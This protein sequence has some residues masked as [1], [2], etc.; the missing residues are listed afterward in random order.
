MLLPRTCTSLSPTCTMRWA[1]TVATLGF[2]RCEEAAR[3]WVRGSGDVERCR[4]ARHAPGPG[5]DSSRSAQGPRVYQGWNRR[6]PRRDRGETEGVTEA[7]PA[8]PPAERPPPGSR[9]GPAPA[10]GPAQPGPPD[11]P[12]PLPA[13]PT[14][15]CRELPGNGERGL[16]DCCAGVASV[17]RRTRSW[18]AAR[19]LS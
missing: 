10:P 2:S 3:S 15:E 9:P 5:A 6:G 18:Q 17:A 8:P 7:R 11:P 19:S 13:P 14:I 16:S 4:R 12:R 1:Q